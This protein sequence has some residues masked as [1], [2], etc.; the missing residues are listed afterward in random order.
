M[1]SPAP[2]FFAARPR[3]NPAPTGLAP[4]SIIYAELIKYALN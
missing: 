3:R 2:D 4:F 1:I